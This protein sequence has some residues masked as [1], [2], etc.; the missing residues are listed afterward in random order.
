MATS[1]KTLINMPELD[2]ADGKAQMELSTDKYNNGQT[3]SAAHVHFLKDG[4]ITFE[5]FGDFRK[6]LL[7]AQLSRVTQKA[8]DSQHAAVFTPAAIEA[9]KAE[10]IAFYAEKRK[11]A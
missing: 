6:V 10:A 5:C 8:L 2:S 1:P 4:M 9:V 11:K 3:V 7:R